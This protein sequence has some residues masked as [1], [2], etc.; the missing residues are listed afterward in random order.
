MDCMSGVSA[1]ATVSMRQG[2][3]LAYV[4]LIGEI[5][6]AAEPAL[7]EV[8]SQ[9]RTTAPTTVI[10]DLAGITFAGSTL[11]NFVVRVRRSVPTG[12]RLILYRPNPSTRRILE[13]S[14]VD[15]LAVIRD[16]LPAGLEAH[17]D[18]GGP[19]AAVREVV[20]QA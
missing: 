17:G 6:L 8:A 3:A 7:A 4:T 16:Q 11:A 2:G 19:W 13:L 10:L 5:D 1:A 20:R 18:A 14:L 15:K 9:L 12:T